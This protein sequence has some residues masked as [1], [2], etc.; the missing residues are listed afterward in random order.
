MKKKRKQK[1][2]KSDVCS[3]S[4][5]QPK[6]EHFQQQKQTSCLCF[7]CHK[8]QSSVILQLV[9]TISKSPTLL[10]KTPCSGFLLLLTIPSPRVFTFIG[11]RP[12]TD[13]MLSGSHGHLQIRRAMTKITSKGQGGICRYLQ[14]LP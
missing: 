6:W 7:F 13:E 8:F 1:Q 12:W 3:V 4:H 5:C 14:A 2:D 11:T 10:S 9:Y